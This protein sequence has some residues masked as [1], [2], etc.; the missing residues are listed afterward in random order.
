MGL[1]ISPDEVIPELVL[2]D[3]LVFGSNHQKHQ[4]IFVQI[5]V[6]LIW[7]LDIFSLSVNFKNFALGETLIVRIQ[8][9]FKDFTELSH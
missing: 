6:L 8:I 1:Q 4:G 3:P 7:N 5:S 2:V 9:L